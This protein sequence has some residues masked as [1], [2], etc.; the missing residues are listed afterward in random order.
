MGNH[1]FTACCWGLQSD[2]LAKPGFYS[3][4]FVNQGDR[5]KVPPYLHECPYQGFLLTGLMVGEL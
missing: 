3:K 1:L 5:G 4:S 2:S